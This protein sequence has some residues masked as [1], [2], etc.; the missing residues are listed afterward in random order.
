[1]YH[2]L[3]GYTA[4]VAGTERGVT[5]P[6]ATFSP[7][8]GGPFLTRQ[9]SVYAHL[10]GERL[11]KTGAKVWLLNTGWNGT[12]NRIELEY[13][14]AMVTAILD[15]K[16]DDVE[17]TEDPVFHVAVPKSV[18]GVPEELLNPVNTWKDKD[19]YNEKAASLATLFQDNF[20]KIGEGAKEDIV[21]AGP[22][23]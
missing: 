7:C 21:A 14:R 5:E 1:M 8:F 4:K 22:T 23:A 12:G 19:A 15:G 2:F 6:T 13:T 10:L 9:P 3:S 18:P 16:L 20:K 11:E 17:Y